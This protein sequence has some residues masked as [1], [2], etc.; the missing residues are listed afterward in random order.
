MFVSVFSEVFCLYVPVC[1]GVRVCA[2]A[3]LQ[4]KL[5]TLKGTRS[6]FWMSQHVLHVLKGNYQPIAAAQMWESKAC[7][8][9]ARGRIY[10]KY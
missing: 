5:F 7:S 1:V 6:V 9:D 10:F 3:C 8:L 2:S 4:C